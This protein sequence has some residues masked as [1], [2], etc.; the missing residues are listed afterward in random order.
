MKKYLLLSMLAG[1]SLASAT[2][3]SWLDGG[4]V[5]NTIEPK[6]TNST[7]SQ[8]V[9]KSVVEVEI[10]DKV[11]LATGEEITLTG[12]VYVKTED[13]ESILK[14]AETNGY[15]ARVDEYTEGAIH[16]ETTVEQS[17]SIANS[18]SRLEGVT[19]SAPKF[20]RKLIAK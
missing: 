10:Q 15:E 11:T 20:Q 2:T 8:V 1:F 5:V 3:V 13:I 4:S 19:T 6:E 18:I 17:I 9:S 16:I 12:G 7:E 14:W